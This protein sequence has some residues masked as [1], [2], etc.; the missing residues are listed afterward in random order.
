MGLINKS[1]VKEKTE[2]NVSEEFLAELE[3]DTE[4]RIKKA[5]ERARANHRSTVFA[6]D[7]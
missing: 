3:K 7:L 4:T 6:R 2:L 1:S 5:E